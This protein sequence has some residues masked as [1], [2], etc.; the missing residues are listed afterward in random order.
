MSLES[1]FLEAFEV[2][3]PDDI[4]RV[5]AAGASEKSNE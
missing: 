2:R 5:L 4:R 3:S 1:E